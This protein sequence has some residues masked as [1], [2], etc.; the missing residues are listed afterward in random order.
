MSFKL[1]FP[2]SPILSPSLPL[3]PHGTKNLCKEESIADAANIDFGD[4]TTDGTDCCQATNESLLRDFHDF[5]AI[6]HPVS[7][8][9]KDGTQYMETLLAKK[10]KIDV[11]CMSVH[12]DSS[13]GS[14]SSR[15]GSEHVSSGETT[16][17][18]LVYDF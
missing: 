10:A 13:L 8:R 17:I 6:D 14:N 16:Y 5:L 18:Q 11:Y 7:S 12:S 1:C 4:E 15:D 2:V 3:L 9:D